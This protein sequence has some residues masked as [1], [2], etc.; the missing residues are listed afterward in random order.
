MSFRYPIQLFTCVVGYHQ[1]IQG[2]QQSIINAIVPYAKSSINDEDK[3]SI[4]QQIIYAAECSVA[5]I[6]NDVPDKAGKEWE[7]ALGAMKK[8]TAKLQNLDPLSFHY[9]DAVLRSDDEKY[10]LLKYYS[11]SYGVPEGDT[12]TIQLLHTHIIKS[13]TLMDNLLSYSL[14]NAPQGRSPERNPLKQYCYDLHRI[15]KKYTGLPLTINSPFERFA[16]ECLRP[17]QGIIK[18]SYTE[19]SLR[20]SIRALSVDAK[21]KQK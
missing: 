17:L 9:L 16:W 13:M 20:K 10:Q 3:K 5:S 19:E 4:I 6:V 18:H 2:N 11:P 12:L 7:Q 1:A 21:K 14:K 15:F 8:A